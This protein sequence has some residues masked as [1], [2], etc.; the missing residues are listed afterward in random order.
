MR[1]SLAALLALGLA[2]LQF[3]AVLAVVLTSYLTSERTLLN[4][5]RSLLTDV[6]YNATEHTKGFLDP[7]RSAAE[8]AA[9]LAQHRV[10]ASDDSALLEQFLFQQLRVTPNFSGLYYGDEN[11]SFVMVMRTETEG[12]FRSKIV[13]TKPRR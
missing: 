11:G 5:A 10:V 8:L 1:N 12:R 4:H 3:I 6:G 7:A 2:G 13:L 9:R